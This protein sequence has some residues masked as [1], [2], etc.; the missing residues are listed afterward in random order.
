MSGLAI[1]PVISCR[2]M[3]GKSAVQ[4]CTAH[5]MQLAVQNQAFRKG[6]RLWPSSAWEG[7]RA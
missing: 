2:K 6:G 5:W 7:E 3:T 1:L 4:N